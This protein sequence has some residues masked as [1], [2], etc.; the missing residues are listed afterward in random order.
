VTGR[1][2]DPSEHSKKEVR[3]VLLGLVK[4]GWSIREAGHWGTLYCPCQ[5]VCTCIAV[6]VLL[7]ILGALRGELPTKHAVVRCRLMIL[8]GRPGLLAFDNDSLE[9]QAR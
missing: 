4:D 3:A 8:G 1:F 2:R 5:P 9:R 6:G 7:R